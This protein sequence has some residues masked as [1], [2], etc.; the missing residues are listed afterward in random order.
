MS[1]R[2]FCMSL[3]CPSVRKFAKPLL[4]GKRIV[5]PC[6]KYLESHGHNLVLMFHIQQVP[7]SH[8]GLLEAPLIKEQLK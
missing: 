5:I 2:G 1:I 4:P 6:S 7:G 3:C 8:L